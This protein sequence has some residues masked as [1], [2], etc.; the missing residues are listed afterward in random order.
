MFEELVGTRRFKY[1]IFT[2]A[3]QQACDWLVKRA[4]AAIVKGVAA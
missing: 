1:S 4:D 2:A 3:A